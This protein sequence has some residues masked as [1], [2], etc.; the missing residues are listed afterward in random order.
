MALLA[1]KSSS[2]KT[3]SA[4]GSIPVVTVAT[5]LRAISPGRWGQKSRLAQKS[6][7]KILEVASVDCP[8]KRADQADLAVP[9][10]PKGT[11]ASPATMARAI[12]STTS[13]RPMYSCFSGARS[14]VAGVGRFPPSSLHCP[15]ILQFNGRDYVD[16]SPTCPFVVGLLGAADNNWRGEKAILRGWPNL[17]C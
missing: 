11:V 8:G 15:F 7:E 13:S 17:P 4:S 10:G 9:G 6:R 5:V 2:R 14:H 3:N 16:R 1:L 12:R